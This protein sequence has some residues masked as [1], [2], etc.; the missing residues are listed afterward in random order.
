MKQGDFTKVAKHYHNRPAYS[1]MLIEKLI[2]CINDTNKQNLNVVE[3]GA[4]TGKLTK[5]L[6][7]EFGLNI[8][9]VEPNDNMREEGIKYTKDYSNITWKKGSGEETNIESNVADW[10]I[11]ASSFH[12]TDP[13]KSLPEFNRIL[14]GG[15]YFTAIWNPRHIVKGSVFDEIETEI[16]N[17]VPE[18]D[19][20]SSGT[21]NV[22]KWEEILVSTGDFT[23]CFFMECDYKELWDKERYLGAWHSVNDI[24]AQAGE[25]RW[26]EILDMI[27]AKISHMQ[28]IEIPYKIRAW[29]ARKA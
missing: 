18:L 28:S 16:K 3:V 26:K 19:R 14:T 2:R 24:Q 22:K 7:N 4:G 15:G 29:T 23:D 6:A 20:V 5:I 8:V 21:Q 12:W 11:M 17:I 13:K 27:E 10:V 1:S 25:K 9:A